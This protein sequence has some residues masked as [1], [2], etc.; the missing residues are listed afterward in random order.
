MAFLACTARASLLPGS[1]SYRCVMDNKSEVRGFLTSRR[2]RLSP[3]QVGL[4]NVGRTRRVHGLRR[5][6]VAMLSGVSVEYYAKL[7]RGNLA[8]A[9][10]QVLDA[11]AAALRLNEAER[12]YLF[13]LARSAAGSM[14]PRRAAPS[15]RLP[16]RV[17]RLLDG[18]PMVPAYVRNRRLDI[19]A[20]NP[21]ARALFCD[22]L[23]DTDALGTEPPN[24]GRYLFLDPR[25]RLFYREWDTVAQDIVAAMRSQAGRNPYDRAFTNLVGELSTRSDEFRVWWAQHEVRL[26]HSSLKLLHHPVAGDLEFDGASLDLAGDSGLTLIA[27]TYETASPTTAALGF[28]ASWNKSD[29]Q[30]P[31]GRPSTEHRT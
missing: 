28:L 20:A 23:N 29:T 9:S 17:A 1:T 19:L 13:D 8:G 25:S 24:L 10:D 5:E 7:E 18:M 2:A 22:V 6:E 31:V 11:L 21:L 12:G 14:Q 30:D 15:Q 16:E 4:P 3:E 27:Y 26:T